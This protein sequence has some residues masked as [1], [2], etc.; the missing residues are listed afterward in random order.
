MKKL[1]L[2]PVL[3]ALAS[4]ATTETTSSI[5]VEG[6][7]Y[8]TTAGCKRDKPLGKF[9]PKCDHPIVGFRGFNGGDVIVPQVGAPGG[10]GF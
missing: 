5:S 6:H 9:D 10:F 2:V 4:C 8:K 7:P 3:L 1:L